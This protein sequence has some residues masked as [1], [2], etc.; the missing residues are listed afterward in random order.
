MSEWGQ[1]NK[2]TPRIYRKGP[3]QCY[4]TNSVQLF[5]SISLQIKENKFIK[6]GGRYLHNG[7]EV[8]LALFS[9]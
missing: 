9:E 1:N 4:W 5:A 8:L 2:I 7:A 3:A 6:S